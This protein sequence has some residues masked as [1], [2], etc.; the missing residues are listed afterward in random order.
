M[1]EGQIPRLVVWPLETGLIWEEVRTEEEAVE[2]EEKMEEGDETLRDT[3][4]AAFVDT[5]VENKDQDSLTD[6]L[7][8]LCG[9]HL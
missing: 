2:K 5:F 9:L 3:F 4:T 1:E 7:N 6:V 8:K